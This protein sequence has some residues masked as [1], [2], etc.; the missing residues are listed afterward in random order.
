L[1][2]SIF[3]FEI[4][5]LKEE[6]TKRGAKRVLFQLPEGLKTQ[7]PCLAST[8]EKLGS[9]A[10]VSADPCYGAC[11][12]A[13]EAAEAL[14][15]DLVVHYGHSPMTPQQCVPTVY[16]EAKTS[17]SLK[18]AVELALPLLEQWKNIG[19]VT[20]IQ[21]IDMLAEA[22]TMLLNSGKSVEV[23]DARRLE[24]AGQITGCD[25]SNASAV[26]KEVDAFL[27]VGGGRFHAV[28][29]GLATSKP[30]VA[31]DP[32]ERRAFSVDDDVRRVAKQR[33]ASLSEAENARCFGVLI[34]LKSGQKRIDEA[35]KVKKK[36]EKKGKQ[37]TLLAVREVIPEVLMQFP[38]LEAFVNTACPRIALEAASKFSRPVLT[39][40]EALVVTGEFTWEELLKKGLFAG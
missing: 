28:G 36:L 2:K 8:A 27:F 26:A 17:L 1:K 21:H 9:V 39:V 31:A 5:R 37:V 40:N 34:G 3:D 15:A 20:T 7:G 19:L 12:L 30:T 22:R 23:G 24:Q 4:E 14:G 35:L 18:P 6:I 29:V 13:F 11:D 38:S 10:I 33:W 16:F 25:Y 32:F